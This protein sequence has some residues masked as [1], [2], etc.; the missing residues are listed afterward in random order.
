MKSQEGPKFKGNSSNICALAQKEGERLCMWPVGN[1]G[2][3]PG[4]GAFVITDGLSRGETVP[5]TQAGQ[6][7]LGALRE[8]FVFHSLPVLTKRNVLT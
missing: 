2:S 1:E 5:E 7:I 8:S 3:M 6:V 4:Q